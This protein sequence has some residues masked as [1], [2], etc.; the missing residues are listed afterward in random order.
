MPT[1][2]IPFCNESQKKA[3]FLN[4]YDL[5]AGMRDLGAINGRESGTGELKY[6]IRT[7][8]RFDSGPRTQDAKLQFKLPISIIASSSSRP[9]LCLADG[10]YQHV[11][12]HYKELAS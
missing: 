9:H 6:T 12:S 10:K 8:C 1:K 3:N 7:G 5:L 11:D 4:D 2:F